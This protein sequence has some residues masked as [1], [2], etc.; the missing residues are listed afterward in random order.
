MSIIPEE[1]NLGNYELIDQREALFNE[2]AIG[3]IEQIQ[4]PTD[5]VTQ[6]RGILYDLD[7]KLF[8]AGSIIPK[9]DPDPEIFFN[10]VVQHWLNRHPVLSKAEV[11][12][13][14]GGLHI[15]LRPEPAIVIADGREREEWAQIIKVVQGALPIDP[16]QPGILANTRPIGSINGKNRISVKQLRPPQPLS[17]EEIRKLY[18][19]MQQE[20]FAT[21]FKILT[22]ENSLTPCPICKKD[23]S[24]LDALK[25]EGNCYANCGKITLSRLYDLCLLERA[26]G[27]EKHTHA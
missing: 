2:G 1:K 8:R 11:R 17:A 27:Q 5:L 26:D 16:E 19:E 21:I 15:I 20:P 9:I 12:Q 13:S 6:V 23:G 24:K 14:G 25:W 4:A 3:P 18:S 7:L 22:G 10:E